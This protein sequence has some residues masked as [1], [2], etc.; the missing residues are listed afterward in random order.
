MINLFIMVMGIICSMLVII[1]FMSV[2]NIATNGWIQLIPLLATAAG[3]IYIGRTGSTPLNFREAPGVWLAL[4]L[5]AGVII[6]GVT[7]LLKAIL[8]G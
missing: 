1:G 3:L 6:G 8:Q 4:S 7:L 2:F 5:G